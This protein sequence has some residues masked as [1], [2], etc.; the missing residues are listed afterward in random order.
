M[1]K[2][3]QLRNVSGNAVAMFSARIQLLAIGADWDILLSDLLH[4][5]ATGRR[6]I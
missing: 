5:G 3:L 4:N 2:L 6:N 1:A